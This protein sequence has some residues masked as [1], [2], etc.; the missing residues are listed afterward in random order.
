MDLVLWRAR[1]HTQDQ[2]IWI[3]PIERGQALTHD[4]GTNVT[5]GGTTRL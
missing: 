5:C 4:T 3:P 1:Q 2:H